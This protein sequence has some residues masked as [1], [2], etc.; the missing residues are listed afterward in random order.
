MTHAGSKQAKRVNKMRNENV[1]K[2]PLKMNGLG[3]YDYA[4]TRSVLIKLHDVL[5]VMVS[6][7]RIMLMELT[8]F[9]VILYHQ[10][11]GNPTVCSTN[12]LK[13]IVAV[14]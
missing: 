6:I 4:V 1:F 11:D 2:N 10:T 12:M 3:S 9:I 13:W 8:M 7:I 5:I 14:I